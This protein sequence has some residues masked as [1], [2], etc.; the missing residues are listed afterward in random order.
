MSDKLL[1]ALRGAVRR[2]PPLDTDLPQSFLGVPRRKKRAEVQPVT[3]KSSLFRSI[4]Y[5]MCSILRAVAIL[6]TC[7]PFLRA[8]LR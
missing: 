1:F 5:I 6:A 3:L 7:F 8:S 4:Q 2:A